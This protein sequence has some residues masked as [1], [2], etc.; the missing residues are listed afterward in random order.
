ME[1]NLTPEYI[2]FVNEG[3]NINTLVQKVI[4]KIQYLPG[5]FNELALLLN[6]YE[7]PFEEVEIEVPECEEIKTTATGILTEKRLKPQFCK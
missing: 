7:D 1:S 5:F 2:N 4:D 3:E 6:K